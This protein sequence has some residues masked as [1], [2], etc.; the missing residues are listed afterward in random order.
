MAEN[1]Y[2]VTNLGEATSDP[3][4]EWS[5]AE[6]NPGGVKIGVEDVLLSPIS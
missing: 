6:G 4:D 3:N 2:E 1:L 5:I